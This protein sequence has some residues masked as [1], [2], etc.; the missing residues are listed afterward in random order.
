MGTEIFGEEQVIGHAGDLQ[1][2]ELEKKAMIK[3]RLEGFR[4]VEK[5]WTY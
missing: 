2:K 4:S 1:A 3:K 5:R